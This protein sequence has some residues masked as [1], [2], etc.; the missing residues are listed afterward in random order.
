[1]PQTL[2][3]YWQSYLGVEWETA[4]ELLLHTLGNLTLTAYNSE[5]SNDTWETKKKL[6]DESHLELNEY[7]KDRNSWK[8]E[9][10][11][12]RS[13]YLADIALTIWPYFGN[14]RQNDNKDVTGTIPRKMRI[15]GQDFSLHS[16][17][18]VLERTANTIADL[19]P[20]K[21]EQIMQQYPRLINRDKSKFREKR[22]LKNGAFLEVN[23]SAKEIQRF[24][25]QVMETIDLSADDLLVET[26]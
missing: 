4:Y 11:E 24:C 5:L 6:L 18:D 2:T 12:Q 8:R 3:P 21:F 22:E 16:W 23:L 13:S 19:E 15:L 26:E 17:R 20:E 10:I 14:T 25:F 1:M 9:D 7:F